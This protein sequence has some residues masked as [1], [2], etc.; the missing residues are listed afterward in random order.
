MEQQTSRLSPC[1]AG[2]LVSG[3]TTTYCCIVVAEHSASVTP[4]RLRYEPSVLKTWLLDVKSIARRAISQD[5]MYDVARCSTA[6]CIISLPTEYSV[7]QSLRKLI[8][9]SGTRPYRRRLGMPLHGQ[10]PALCRQVGRWIHMPPLLC[11]GF[12]NDVETIIDPIGS[13]NHSTETK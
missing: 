2:R 3:A 12:S 5:R 6:V 10:G 8:V 11:C 1:L 4:W 7:G 9:P 13:Q